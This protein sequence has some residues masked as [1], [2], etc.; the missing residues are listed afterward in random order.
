LGF[1]PPAKVIKGNTIKL[2]WLNNAFRELSDNAT[3]VVISQHARKHILALIE[4][5]L[6]PDTLASRV[7]LMYLPLLTNLNNVSDYSWGVAVL[8]SLY[9]LLN[10]GVDFNQQNIRGCM[11][12]L[13]SWAWYRLTSIS[14]TIDTLVMK[15]LK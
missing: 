1:L 8:A 14:P 15:T 3:K 6:M 5:L 9:H 12:L 2:S 7:H 13:Q 4:T 11:L 10:H